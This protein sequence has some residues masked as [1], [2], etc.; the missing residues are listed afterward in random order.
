MGEQKYKPDIWVIEFQ[1][2]N[3]EW[4]LVEEVYYRW[5]STLTNHIKAIRVMDF[6]N[7]DC[8]QQEINYMKMSKDHERAREFT[9]ARPIKVRLPNERT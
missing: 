3:G 1:A 4:E 6:P 9:T 7:E 2:E 8:A 5:D